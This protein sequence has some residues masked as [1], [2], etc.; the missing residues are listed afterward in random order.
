MTIEQ[1]LL[2]ATLIMAAI[3]VSYSIIKISNLKKEV[4]SR[5][6]KNVDFLMTKPPMDYEEC[7]D[8][9]DTCISNVIFDLELRY[10]LNDV[11]YIKK[12]DEEVKE[13]TRDVMKLIS[14]NVMEQMQCY[15]TDSY[16]IQYI[17]RNI[18]NFIIAYL[19]EK[20]K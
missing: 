13:A 3:Y 8:V 11:R 5:M 19:K 20:N 1:W 16:I 18:R 10:E 14:A 15:V 12:V 6:K 4:A 2:L 7:K 17:S 9:I